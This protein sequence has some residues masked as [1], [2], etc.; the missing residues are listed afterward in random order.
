MK[1]LVA[2]LL[3][4][5]ACNTDTPKTSTG[6]TEREADSVIGQS[7]LPGAGGVK[8]AMAAQDTARAQAARSTPLLHATHSRNSLRAA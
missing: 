6:R 8:K 7:R 5:A 3:L 1:T 4:C 2:A